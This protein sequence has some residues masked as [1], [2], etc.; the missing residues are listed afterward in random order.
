MNKSVSFIG[1]CTAVLVLA[2]CTQGTTYGTGESHEIQ[3]I[4][5]IGNMLSIRPDEQAKI[6]YRSRPELILPASKQNLPA[7]V[8]EVANADDQQWPESQ[9]TR[10]AKI[11]G[12]APEADWRSGDVDQAFLQ[13]EKPGILVDSKNERLKQ[14]SRRNVNSGGE[15]FIEEWALEKQGKGPSAVARQRREQIAFTQGSAPRKYLTEPPSIYRTPSANA[16]AGDLG[17]TPEEVL[18]RQKQAEKE[19][20]DIDGGI[21]TPGG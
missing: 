15:E 9:E 19:R 18:E 11:Q 14:L 20:K 5:S 13:S 16:E 3:T 17:V 1:M 10:I 12:A 8:E 6:N 21:I 4:K 2:G 7:P